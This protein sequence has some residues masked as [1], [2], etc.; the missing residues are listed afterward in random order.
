MENALG[1]IVLYVLDTLESQRIA[2][3]RAKEERRLREE[4]ERKRQREEE[5]RRR[6]WQESEE[7]LRRL[8][9]EA[10]LWSECKRL[11]EYIAARESLYYRTTLGR[12]SHD[13]ERRW[14]SWAK[15][16]FDW[17]DPINQFP[18]SDH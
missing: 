2:T 9:A 5:E 6:S 10:E 15:T 13:A 4:A 14:L 7:R 16:Y 3:D 17:L 18:Q 11:R 8:H 1:E 12:I